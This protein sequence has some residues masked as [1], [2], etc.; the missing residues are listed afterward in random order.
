MRRCPTR[1]PS[2]N[3]GVPDFITGS[4][5]GIIAPGKTPAEIV[6]KMHAK[7]RRL[8]FTA[9]VKEKLSG[10]G[11]EPMGS[12]PAETAEFMRRE[13]ERWSNLIRVTGYKSA[14]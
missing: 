11:A 4:W 1:P 2:S 8:L 13:R 7:T 5:Q 12:T 6:A 9:E 10:Q 3:R 14:Q